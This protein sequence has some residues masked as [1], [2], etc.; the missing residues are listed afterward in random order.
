MMMVSLRTWV[1]LI[2]MLVL[3][4][5]VSSGGLDRFIMREDTDLRLQLA[6][7]WAQTVSVTLPIAEGRPRVAV[8]W[9]ARDDSGLL[10]RELRAWLGRQNVQLVCDDWWQEP[11][12][13]FGLTSVPS[14][15]EETSQ[16]VSKWAADIVVACEVKEWVT[17]PSHEAHLLGTVSVTDLRTGKQIYLQDFSL[18]E[19]APKGS[20]ALAEVPVAVTPQPHSTELHARDM[21]LTVA[22]LAPN[23][24]PVF[25]A[26]HGLVSWLITVLL[27]PFGM[28]DFLKRVLRRQSNV[29]NFGML[30]GWI[31][32]ALGLAWLL[33]AWRLTFLPLTL[34][35]LA[36]GGLSIPYFGYVCHQ[37]QK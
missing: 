36:A 3:L 29:A 19:V 14:N 11:G 18:P 7:Q 17:Y 20:A 12:Y 37:F 24:S 32:V 22:N 1:M 25:G 21:A 5:Y 26:W 8:A 10:T 34:A 33:W 31:T 15:Y 13:T 23:T 9:I 30:L 27:L 6:R 28:G 2:V 16:S 4:G 35:L